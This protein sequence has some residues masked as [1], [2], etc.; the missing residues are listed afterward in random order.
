MRRPLFGM[1]IFCAREVL[2]YAQLDATP[3]KL[4]KRSSKDLYPGL[5]QSV[6]QG[7][8]TKV[9]KQGVSSVGVI[10]HVT[11]FRKHRFGSN[12]EVQGDVQNLPHAGK[13]DHELEGVLRQY[14]KLE[15]NE[16]QSAEQASDA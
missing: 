11:C 2:G 16:G 9:S 5:L 3:A 12:C 6:R 4:E 8:Y 13:H 14:A 1:F 10:F 15:A 7:R